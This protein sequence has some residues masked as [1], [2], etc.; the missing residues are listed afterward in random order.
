MQ[1]KAVVGGG[2]ATRADM[3]AEVDKKQGSRSSGK[4]RRTWLADSQL[5]VSNF[6][7]LLGRCVGAQV[8]WTAGVAASVLCRMEYALFTVH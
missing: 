4:R 6:L 8:G 2:G 5:V 3:W 1:G 7:T